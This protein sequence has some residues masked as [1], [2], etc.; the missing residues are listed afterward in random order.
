[1]NLTAENVQLE[2]KGLAQ[3]VQTWNPGKS[4]LTLYGPG[5][6]GEPMLD[7]TCWKVSFGSELSSSVSSLAMYDVVGMPRSFGSTSMMQ[8]TGWV[9]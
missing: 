1:M 3:M 5:P 7:G 9:Q 8:Y 6:R 4:K 2:Q